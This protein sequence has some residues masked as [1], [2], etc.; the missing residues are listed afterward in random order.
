MACVTLSLMYLRYFQL[1]SYKNIIDRWL[2]HALEL[3]L[4]QCNVS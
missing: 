1:Y 2:V 3:T 4:I